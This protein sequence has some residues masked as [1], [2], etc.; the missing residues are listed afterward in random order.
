MISDIKTE[1][2]Q[3]LSDAKHNQVT[4]GKELDADVKKLQIDVTN[5]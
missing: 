5:L 4:L 3:N 2:H 1:V